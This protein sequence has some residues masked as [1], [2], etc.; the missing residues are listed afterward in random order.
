MTP[1]TRTRLERV[2]ASASIVKLAVEQIENELGGPIDTEF[3]AEML[4][5]LF[6]EA[7]PQDGVFGSLNQLLTTASKAAALTP[8]DGEDAESVACAIEE[9]AAFVADSAGMRLYLATSTL[10]LQ[11]ERP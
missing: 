9:A 3:L 6:D 10:H 4:R 5:E 1:A 8:L 7:F 11:G 2:H